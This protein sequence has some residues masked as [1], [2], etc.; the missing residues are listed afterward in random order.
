[1]YSLIFPFY[2]RLLSF[3]YIIRVDKHFRQLKIFCLLAANPWQFKA[4]NLHF[5]IILLF[6]V[7][8]GHPVIFRVVLV[9]P[10]C[11][12]RIQLRRPAR[13]HVTKDQSDG[14]RNAKRDHN[15]CH[16]WRRVD[17]HDGTDSR[18]C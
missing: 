12:D 18:T 3:N 17:S 7:F 10:Q 8:T 11:V 5:P 9:C 16:G 6:S 13:R 2:C 1:M 15:C 4:W 14:N